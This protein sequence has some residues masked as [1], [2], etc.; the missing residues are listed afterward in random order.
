[1]QKFIATLSLVFLSGS[2][3]AQS[4]PTAC[5]ALDSSD[6]M[7]GCLESRVKVEDD[8]LQKVYDTLMAQLKDRSQKDRAATL[9]TAQLAW[10]RFRD[11][12]CKFDFGVSE[13]GD[14]SGIAQQMC[15]VRETSDRRIQL[16]QALTYLVTGSVIPR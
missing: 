14:Q 12:Q 10:I 1:M 15:L 2:A 11:A 3:F 7:Y 5:L 4:L 9:R 16:E 13:A 8:T 6:K